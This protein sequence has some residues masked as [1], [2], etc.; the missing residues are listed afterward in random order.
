[1]TLDFADVKPSLL[2]WVITGLMAVTFISFW[3]FIF[4]MWGQNIPILSSFAHL[5][6]SI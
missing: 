5:F 3:K 1:M 6:A 2:N 4:S